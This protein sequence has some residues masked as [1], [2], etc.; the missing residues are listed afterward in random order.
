M[1]YQ[2]LARL[3]EEEYERFK[4]VILLPDGTKLTWL[5][6]YWY[7][8]SACRCENNEAYIAGFYQHLGY[9]LKPGRFLI[10]DFSVAEGFG[11][12]FMHLIQSQ[13]GRIYR[14]LRAIR[15]EQG[16]LLLKDTLR[17]AKDAIER[18]LLGKLSYQRIL[19]ELIL[20]LSEESRY[21][22]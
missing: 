1:S 21:H 16:G 14:I 12:G 10:I 7:Y 6:S 3:G 17:F 13:F 11:A 20:I 22:L 4:P 8:N 18:K 19:Q 5:R 15:F 9:L 2:P